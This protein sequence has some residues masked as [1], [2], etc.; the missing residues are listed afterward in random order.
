MRSIKLIHKWTGLLIGLFFILSCLS[1]AF[2]EI[3]KI[4]QSYAPVFGWMRRL[5]TTLFLADTGSMIIGIASLL[6]AIEIIS[7][8][9]LW[10]EVV[11]KLGKAAKLHGKSRLSPILKTITFRFPNKKWAWHVS[12]GFWSG[13]PILI[14]IL[15]GL[16]WAFGWYSKIIYT[17]F[18]TP[19]AS[20][21]TNWGSTASSA[22]TSGPNLFHTLS[23]LHTG[24]WSAPV[25]RYLWL[26]AVLL[27]LITA[28]T[29]L[30][31][32]FPKKHPD[33]H[34]PHPQK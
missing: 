16:T 20:T 2:I 5:H 32:T 10:G 6:A 22:P 26:L 18:D 7:G 12:T 17:L 21:A 24:N 27:A 1:G 9:I 30:L 15:T 28:L 29:G 25:S 19:A 11:S 31:I 8:Y 3:G 14:M 23:A 4:A 34:P 13:I 33:N